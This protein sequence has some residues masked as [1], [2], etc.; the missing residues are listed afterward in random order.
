MDFLNRIEELDYLNRAYR[1]SG[2]NLLVLYGRRR[3][4][5]TRLIKE[6]V[7]DKPHLYFLCDKEMEIESLR[8]MQREI[9]AFLNDPLLEGMTFRDWETLFQYWLRHARLRPE[10]LKPEGF[11]SKIV[12]VIDE[13]QYLAGANPAFPSIL[14]R[15]WDE[16]LQSQNI[17]LILCGSLIHMMYNTALSYQSP[18]YGRRTGQMRLEPLSFLD[19]RAFF[20]NLSFEEWVMFY[21]VTGG[22]PRYIACIDPQKTVFENIAHAILDPNEM[23]YAEPRFILGEEVKEPMTYFSILRV[24][25]EGEHKIGKIASKLRVPANHLT[26]YLEVL[27]DL[28]IL[29]REVPITESQPQKSKRGLY[30]IKDPFF[31]FWFRYVFPFQAQLE[32]GH[33]EYVL[34]KITSEFP[35]FVGTTFESI[36]QEFLAYWNAQNLLPFHAEKWGRWW[37]ADQ[38]IDVVA[39]NASVKEIL[40]VECKWSANPLDVNILS[41]LK[42]KTHAVNWFND[43]RKETFLLLGRSGV[44]PRLKEIARREGILLATGFDLLTT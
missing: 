10:G 13:F 33:T 25:A 41:E 7:Q 28:G 30:F 9:A 11:S 18:L 6:F 39:L 26:K 44:T 14:Q 40:F 1:T 24:I 38:E 4:G 42:R 21:S 27:M 5:K 23:L 16:H 17:F 43:Q 15:L 2:S 29:A 35:A 32:M 20:P 36:A 19:F 22:V 31:R 8:R 3:V 12:L 37:H 34:E